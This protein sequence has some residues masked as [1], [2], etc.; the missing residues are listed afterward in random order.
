[1]ER[2][3]EKDFRVSMQEVNQLS[4][5]EYI[6]TPRGGYIA[7]F[8]H[9]EAIMN[10]FTKFTARI[11]NL[12]PSIQYDNNNAHTT[13]AGYKGEALA[14]FQVNEDILLQLKKLCEEIETG[15]LRGIRITFNEW[16]FN[17]TSIIVAGK[18]NSS[19]WEVSARLRE[20]AEKMGLDLNKLTKPWGAHI[21]AARFIEDSTK[22]RELKKLIS[23]GPNLG[24]SKPI[25]VLVG[26]YSCSRSGFNLYPYFI[27]SI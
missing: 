23:K 20:I 18:P 8:R 5:S 17:D 6:A 2:I 25:T 15:L 19:F 7:V 11:R 3:Y 9:S 13:I 21:T 12:V 26:H 14:D 10:T 22:V 27:R 16:L 1:M 24:E 4:M